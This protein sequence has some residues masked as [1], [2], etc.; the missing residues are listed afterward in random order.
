MKGEIRFERLYYYCPRCRTYFSPLDQEL[1]VCPALCLTPSLKRRVAW[2]AARSSFEHAAEDLAELIDVKV[3][4][5]EFQRVALEVGDAFERLNLERD[6]AWNRPVSPQRPAPE[7]EI[8]PERL[9]VQADATCVLTVKGEEHKSVYC[10][11]VFDLDAIGRKESNGRPFIADS[12]Y[13]GGA[14]GF[15]DFSARL[16][17]LAYRRGAR[18]AKQVAFLADGA[19]CL[20]GWAEAFFG[21]EAVLIQDFWHVCE[22]LSHLAQVLYGEAWRERFERWKEQLAQ[23]RVDSVIRQLRRLRRQFDGPKRKCLNEQIGYLEAGRGRMDY[24]RYRRE[25]WPIGSGAIEGTCKHLVKERF[26]VTGAQWRRRN[27]PQVLALRVAQANH[28]WDEYWNRSQA[29]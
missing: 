6:E 13:A 9:V 25:G 12:R 15:E 21:P 19:R 1:G 16:K 26:C 5:S 8:A 7:P 4:S 3:S 27:I 29:A 14:I 22:R 23:S 2:L 20:W 17:A 28:E 10:G 11:R 18:R 24:A